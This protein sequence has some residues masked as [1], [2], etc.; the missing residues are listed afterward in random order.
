MKVYRQTDGQTMDIPDQKST[1][2]FSGQV[3]EDKNN[4]E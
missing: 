4:Q 2:E 3:R 1:L